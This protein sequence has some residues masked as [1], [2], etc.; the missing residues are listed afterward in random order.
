MLGLSLGLKLGTI[1]GSALAV[2]VGPSDPVGVG[3]LLGEVLGA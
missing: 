2:S 1:E 3:I